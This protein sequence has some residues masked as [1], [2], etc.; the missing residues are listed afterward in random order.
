M[1]ST[2]WAFS[3]MFRILRA[4]IRAHAHVIL[5]VGQV[6]M[7]STEAGWAKTLFS[8]TSAAAV[9]WLIIYPELRPLSATKK[10]GSPLKA[11]LTSRSIRRSE[12]FANSAKAMPRKSRASD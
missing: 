1:A 6:G 3:N 2:F 8:E 4:E 5:L 7:E 9:Y 10:G 11:G 12:M